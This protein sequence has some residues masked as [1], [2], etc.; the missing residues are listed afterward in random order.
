[1]LNTEQFILL[2]GSPEKW[3]EEIREQASRAA[4]QNVGISL[5]ELQEDETPPKE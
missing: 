5:S 4:D 3:D 1:M 2:A